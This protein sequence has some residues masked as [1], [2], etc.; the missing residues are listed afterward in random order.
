MKLALG[1]ATGG[2]VVAHRIDGL[3]S[4]TRA[5]QKM[6][7]SPP[8]SATHPGACKRVGAS[9]AAARASENAPSCLST[10]R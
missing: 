3:R 7:I 5:R 2:N 1:Y 4:S 6:A 10:R 9:Y 8:I